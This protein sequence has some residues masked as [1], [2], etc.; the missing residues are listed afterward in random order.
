[1][2]LAGPL[3]LLKCMD[4]Q[5]KVEAAEATLAGAKARLGKAKE[6]AAS[7]DDALGRAKR[8]V[9]RVRLLCPSSKRVWRIVL[10]G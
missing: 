4:V 1:M 8:E 3:M 5:A 6:D 9:E 7:A 10:H 2:T